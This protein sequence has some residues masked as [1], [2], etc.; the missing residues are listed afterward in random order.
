MNLFLFLHRRSIAN[1]VINAV[2]VENNDITAIEYQ[3]YSDN[4]LENTEIKSEKRFDQIKLYC[5]HSIV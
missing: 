4:K 2:T 5:D 1:K 3:T